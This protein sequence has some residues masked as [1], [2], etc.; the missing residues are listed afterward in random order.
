MRDLH[1]PQTYHCWLWVEWA[2]QQQLGLVWSESPF[3]VSRLH[4]NSTLS[5]QVLI[6]HLTWEL[7]LLYNTKRP[8]YRGKWLCCCQKST[9]TKL[10]GYPLWTHL[11]KLGYSCTS[12]ALPA[13]TT[14]HQSRTIEEKNPI[15]KKRK[16]KIAQSI[17][18]PSPKDLQNIKQR[19]IQHTTN[20]YQCRLEKPCTIFARGKI[21]TPK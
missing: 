14:H 18:T 1:A 17:L 13:R 2:Q 8:K 15:F 16:V 9:T 5:E 21:S 3:P 4:D 7:H 19:Q 11:S 6:K 20:L 10:F 12:T